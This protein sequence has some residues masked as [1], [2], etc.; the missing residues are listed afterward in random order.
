MVL[1]QKFYCCGVVWQKHRRF[2]PSPLKFVGHLERI[3]SRSLYPPA[4]VFKLN[5]VRKAAADGIF[6]PFRIRGD[7]TQGRCGAV[8]V[9]FGRRQFVSHIRIEQFILD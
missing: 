2:P 4:A 9:V 8:V 7:W 3:G 5:A 1:S 6:F